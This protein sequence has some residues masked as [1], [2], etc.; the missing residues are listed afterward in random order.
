MQ[1]KKIDQV[2]KKDENSDTYETPLGDRTSKA[3]SSSI[4]KQVDS[5]EIDQNN[6]DK[7]N[8]NLNYIAKDLD[9]AEIKMNEFICRDFLWLG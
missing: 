9:E 8:Q 7:E 6:N 4:F 1:K 5:K 3:Q 2:K